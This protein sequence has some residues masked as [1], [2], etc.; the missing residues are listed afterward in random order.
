MVKRFPL[1]QG[2]GHKELLAKE[3]LIGHS[4]ASEY[5]FINKLRAR[6]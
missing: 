3:K 5:S 4:Y 1:L 2:N 6:E